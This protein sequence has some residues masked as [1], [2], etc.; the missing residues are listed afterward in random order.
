MSWLAMS[1]VAMQLA[2]RVHSKREVRFDVDSHSVGIDN[3]CS[4]CISPDPLD[5]IGKLQDS[6]SMITGFGGS[7]VQTAKKGML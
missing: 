3:Q 1:S 2:A 7:R 6:N 5:F 4:K